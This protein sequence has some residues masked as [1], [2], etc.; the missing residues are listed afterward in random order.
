MPLDDA[1]N[2]ENHIPDAVRRASQRADEL[3]REHGIAGAPVEEG[4]EADETPADPPA[5]LVAEAP[6]APVDPPA[7]DP[8]VIDWEQRFHTMQGKYN[9]EV[10]RLHGKVETLERLVATM[11][12]P[13]ATPAPPTE[14][15]T[16]V[17]IPPEDLEAYGEDL[18]KAVPRW[19]EP[20]LQPLLQ[21]INTLQR[22]V[23]EL[24]G[25]QSQVTEDIV[26]Q[27]TAAALDADRELAGRWREV[28]TDPQFLTWL[29]EDDPFAGRPRLEMLREAF[30]TGDAT[31]TGRFFKTYFAE[32]TA[33]RQ[34]SPPDPAT[35]TPAG[36]DGRPTLESLASPGRA[37]GHAPGG[38]PEGKRVWTRAE[39]TAFYRDRMNGRYQGREATA[40][41]L[42]QD[43]HAA[44]TEGRIH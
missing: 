9:A 34:P 16:T 40:L 18:I 5:D 3:A 12:T 17:V 1:N 41:S 36:A 31:R 35:H 14:T 27:R 24:R 6:P 4:S 20:K 8:P 2:Y 11:Q 23:Q 7:A 25:G 42:E 37:A 28:N 10:P 38:A 13:A 32:H 21:Q 15:T 19:V 33:T 43:I 39:I 30:A 22:E 26:R 44:V 29:N